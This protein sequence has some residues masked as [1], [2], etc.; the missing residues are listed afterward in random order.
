MKNYTYDS[1]I[2]AGYEI[3]NALITSVSMNM[4]NHCRLTLDIVL[5]GNGWGV[6]YGGYCIGKGYLGAD[7]DFWEGSKVGME[8]VMRI[9]DTIGVSALED[10]KGKYVRVATKG[11]GDTVKIIGNIVKDKWFDYKSFF[12]EAKKRED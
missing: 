6:C 3:K 12:E 9:M 5:E 10:A 1:L 11:W 7:D 4:K 8:A 2:E